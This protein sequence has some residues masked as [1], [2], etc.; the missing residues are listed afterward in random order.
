MSIFS[1]SVSGI[2]AETAILRMIS[3]IFKRIAHRSESIRQCSL[4][5]LYGVLLCPFT[6]TRKY[7]YHNYDCN[8]EIYHTFLTYSAK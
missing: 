2:S 1:R 7:G 3:V 8:R 5:Y 6:G 4:K